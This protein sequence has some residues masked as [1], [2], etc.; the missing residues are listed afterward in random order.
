MKAL[1]KD[2]KDVQY[3]S[4]I[5]FCDMNYKRADESIIKAI[6]DQDRIDQEEYVADFFDCDDFTFAL[7]GAFHHCRETAAMPIF[8]IYV[9]WGEEGNIA[10]HS[11]MSYY[12]NGQIILIEPQSDHCYTV[13]ADWILTFLTG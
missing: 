13:P 1:D 7:M 12:N 8:I 2:F 11:I 6:T 4:N 10:A 9:Q 5:R 3:G